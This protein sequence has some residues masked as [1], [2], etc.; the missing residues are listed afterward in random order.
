MSASSYE[1]LSVALYLTVLAIVASRMPQKNYLSIIAATPFIFLSECLAIILM[2][3]Y[4]E[5]VEI[6]RLFYEYSRDFNMLYDRV[7]WVL[8]FSNGWFWGIPL[9][10]CWKLHELIHQKDEGTETLPHMGKMDEI[11]RA[12]RK[13]ESMQGVGIG[14]QIASELKL[15][16]LELLLP[17]LIFM[18]W[19]ISV[20]C[21]AIWSG[22][23]SYPYSSS[24]IGGLPLL[25]SIAVSS[26][27]VFLAI[28]NTLLVLHSRRTAGQEKSLIDRLLDIGEKSPDV[29]ERSWTWNVF[30]RII[31]YN[32][33]FLYLFIIFWR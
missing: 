3:E 25:R 5:G 13:R 29:K 17:F 10:I 2:Q 8:P 4:F 28:I 18:G 6:S 31:G 22:L 12:R 27:G 26:I 16:L 20:E 30:W 33:V 11:E 1:L 15:L 19:D 9:L 7:P 21:L 23:W 24:T 32:F 14:I